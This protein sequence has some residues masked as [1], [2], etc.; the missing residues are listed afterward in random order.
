MTLVANMISLKH[1]VIAFHTALILM[2]TACSSKADLANRPSYDRDN[3]SWSLYSKTS[4]GSLSG[5][6]KG[7]ISYYGPGFHGKPTASGEKYDQNDL[8]CAHKTLPFGT[9]LK[10]TLL[11][12]GKSVIVRVND[13]GPYIKGRTL[14]VSVKAAKEIG[15]TQQGVGEAQIEIIP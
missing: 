8:T 15:L 7:H 13:R 14:D 12:T 1:F 10:V 2:M 6:F 3:G 9:K 4:S 5:S 11:K